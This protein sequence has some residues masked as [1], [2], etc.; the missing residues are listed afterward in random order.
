M[1]RKRIIKII[2]KTIINTLALIVIV[3]AM[4]TVFLG[5]LSKMLSGHGLDEV[6]TARGGVTTHA[7]LFMSAAVLI[8]IFIFVMFMEIRNEKK[9][10]IKRKKHNPY[11]A[12]GVNRK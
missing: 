6:T 4:G 3:F 10:K 12:S 11:K 5:P 7:A 9:I 8:L 2:K 1:K